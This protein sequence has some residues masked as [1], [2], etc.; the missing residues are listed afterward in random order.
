MLDPK[1]NKQVI[2]T[3]LM[4][5]VAV[6]RHNFKWVKNQIKY[7]SER[8]V[9]HYTKLGAPP[10]KGEGPRV[11][12][13]TAAFHARV[14]SSFPGPG[15]LKKQTKISVLGLRPPGF[16]FRILCLDGCVI[17]PSSGGSPGHLR[18][19]RNQFYSEEAK[20]HHW[21]TVY[22][23]FSRGFNFREGSNSRIQ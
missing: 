17:S 14:R 21:N 4:L 13:R 16:E 22:L 8:R 11:V 20:R 10:T 12:V 19:S 6:A 2:F 5:W 7:L 18:N 1:L 9:N 23:V 3:H 15:G